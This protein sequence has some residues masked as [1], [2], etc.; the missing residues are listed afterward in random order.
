[1]TKEGLLAGASPSPRTNL[2]VA[3]KDIGRRIT[4]TPASSLAQPRARNAGADRTWLLLATRRID[5]TDA[6]LLREAVT[7]ANPVP[8]EAQ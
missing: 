6:S 1:M 7:V 2:H 8:V 4:R 5:A 3:G